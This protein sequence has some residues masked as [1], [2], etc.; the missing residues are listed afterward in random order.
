M[1]LL[2]CKILYEIIT[3]TIH[4][5]IIT[6]NNEISNKTN[7]NNSNVN[8]QNQLDHITVNSVSFNM[9][10]CYGGEFWMGTDD[11]SLTASYWDR[12]KPKHKVK[13]T[14]GFWMGVEL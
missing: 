12:S 4:N 11:A 9:V 6:N 7:D 13:I 14:K 10:Y 5:N 3:K 8:I 2:E 1:E